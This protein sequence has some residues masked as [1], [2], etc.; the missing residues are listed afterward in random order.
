MRK[1]TIGLAVLFIAALCAHSATATTTYD[2]ADYF[3]ITNADTWA[4]LGDGPSGVT[5]NGTRVI[6]TIV[7]N[8]FILSPGLEEYYYTLDASGI[9]IYGNTTE[10]GSDYMFQSPLEAMPKNV[11]VGATYTSSAVGQVQ[12]EST[13]YTT[14]LNTTITGTEDV[15]VNGVTFKNAMKITVVQTNVKS[16]D[17]STSILNTT[18][19][20]V[21]NLGEVKSV[22]DDWGSGQVH[23]RYIQSAL[24][25]YSSSRK[26]AELLSA[27]DPSGFIYYEYNDESISRVSR[28]QR[29]DGSYILVKSYWSSTTTSMREEEYNSDGNLIEVR[30]YYSSGQLQDKFEYYTSGNLKSYYSEWNNGASYSRYTFLDEDYYKYKIPGDAAHAYGQGR[31]SRYEYNNSDG[32]IG[33]QEVEYDGNSLSVRKISDPVWNNDII[34]PNST[35]EQ[36]Y[37]NDGFINNPRVAFDSEGNKIVGAFTID[38][39]GPAKAYVVKY[40]PQGEVLWRNEFPTFTTSAMNVV[41]AVDSL[42]NVYVAAEK[43]DNGSDLVVYKYDKNGDPVGV[44]YQFNSGPGW[45]E[46]AS[47]ILVDPSNNI[48]ISGTTAANNWEARDLYL[49]KLNS[50]LTEAWRRTYD[51][52]YKDYGG[53]L[54]IGADGNVTIYGYDYDNPDPALLTYKITYASDGTVQSPVYDDDLLINNDGW[55]GCWPTGRD[56]KQLTTINGQSIEWSMYGYREGTGIALLQYGMP[57]GNMIVIPPSYGNL[58]SRIF[59]DPITNQG[60]GYNVTFENGT[61]I[62]SL[63]VLSEEAGF[64]VKKLIDPD[65][66]TYWFLWGDNVYEGNSNVVIKKAT[67]GLWTAWTFTPETHDISALMQ[68]Q[69]L[70]GSVADPSRLNLP[71]LGNW[72]EYN[73]R[74]N[75]TVE[76]PPLSTTYEYDQGRVIER[77]EHND[78][79]DVKYVYQ[80]DTINGKVAEL[81]YYEKDGASKLVSTTRYVNGS[82]YDLANKGNWQMETQFTYYTSG[83]TKTYYNPYDQ[84]RYTYENDNYF[85]VSSDHGQGRLILVDW[86]NG[87]GEYYAFTYYGSSLRIKE[88]RSKRTGSNGLVHERLETKM[89]ESFY[90]QPNITVDG[91]GN[92]IVTACVNNNGRIDAY[93]VKYGPTGTRLWS[94][95]FIEG[96]WIHETVVTT[97]SAGNVIV[98]ASKWNN[99]NNT[100]DFYVAKYSANGLTRLWE[101]VYDSGGQDRVRDVLVD[102]DGNI[103]L[104]GTKGYYPNSDILLVKLNPNALGSPADPFLLWDRLYDDNSSEDWVTTADL[105]AG[106]SIILHAT[107]R[108]P[109]PLEYVYDKLKITYDKFGNLSSTV[110]DL[111]EPGGGDSWLGIVESGREL[112]EYTAYEDSSYEFYMSLGYIPGTD[113]SIQEYNYI[114]ELGQNAM[115]FAYYDTSEEYYPNT[116]YRLVFDNGMACDMSYEDLG[117]TEVLKPLKL[118]TPDGYTYWFLWDVTYK[119]VANQYV[120]IE[121]TPENAWNDYTFTPDTAHPENLLDIALRNWTPIDGG[122]DLTGIILPEL[123]AW[124]QAGL[125]VEYPAWPTLYYDS[126]RVRAVHDGATNWIEYYKD[127]DFYANSAHEGRL[128]WRYRTNTDSHFQYTTYNYFKGENDRVYSSYWC[129]H[130]PDEGDMFDYNVETYYNEKFYTG[131]GNDGRGRM[132]QLKYQMGLVPDDMEK[133]TDTYLQYYMGTDHV[134]AGYLDV[135]QGTVV[136]IKGSYKIYYEAGFTNDKTQLTLEDGSIGPSG[137]SSAGCVIDFLSADYNWI[138]KKISYMDGAKVWFIY[139]NRYEQTNNVVLEK[140]AAGVW[141][142]YTFN[143][144]LNPSQ[145]MDRNRWTPIADPSND[146][147][148]LVEGYWPTINPANWILPGWQL[149]SP[150]PPNADIAYKYD[151]QGRIVECIERI[152]NI[153]VRRVYEWDFSQAGRVRE[154]VFNGV[155]GTETLAKKT[156]Y[157]NNADYEITH[158][159]AWQ[160]LGQA[161]YYES[162]NINTFLTDWGRRLTYNDENYWQAPVGQGRIIQIEESNGQVTTIEYHGDSAGRVKSYSIVGQSGYPES[163]YDEDYFNNARIATDSEGNTVEIADLINN[164]TLNLDCY[165]IKKDADSNKIWSK[166]YTDQYVCPRALTV[167]SNGNIIVVGNGGADGGSWVI[168][169]FDTDGTILGGFPVTYGAG[170]PPQ[171]VTTDSEGN[172]IVTG[173]CKTGEQYDFLTIKYGSSGNFLWQQ[174]RNLG[175]NDSANEVCVDKDGIIEVIGNYQDAQTGKWIQYAINYDAAGNIVGQGRIFEN[176]DLS[177]MWELGGITGRHYQQSYNDGSTSFAL[178]Y[179]GYSTLIRHQDNMGVGLGDGTFY[180]YLEI[181]PAVKVYGESALKE[182]GSRI[183][184]DGATNPP[185]RE[186]EEWADPNDPDAGS[187]L[188]KVT[189]INGDTAWL[190]WGA[191]EINGQSYN[192]VVIMQRKSDGAWMARSGFMEDPEDPGSILASLETL[193]IIA[194]FNDPGSLVLPELGDWD[195]YNALHNITVE[196]PP[197]STDYT[198]EIDGLHRVLT[199][200][201]HNDYLDTRYE[202]QWNADN[203]VTEHIYH[204]KNGATTLVSDTVYNN[205]TDSDLSHKPSWTIQSTQVTYYDSG[206]LKSW[207]DSTWGATFIYEDRDYY[208]CAD[209]YNGHGRGRVIS[210]IELNNYGETTTKTFEYYGDTLNL[211]NGTYPVTDNDG[212]IIPGKFEYYTY[213]NEDPWNN[214]SISIDS[215]GNRYV[216]ALI[217]GESWQW[218]ARVIKYNSSGVYQWA[219]ECDAG[220]SS[221]NVINAVDSNGNVY[222]SV[223]KWDNDGGHVFVYKIDADGNQVG[224]PYIYPVSGNSSSISPAYIKVDPLNNIF[225]LGVTGNWPDNSLF[226]IKLNSGLTQQWVRT[227]VTGEGNN[228]HGGY[229]TFGSN[230]TIIL[231]GAQHESIAFPEYYQVT[232]DT[233]GTEISFE[234]DPIGRCFNIWDPWCGR[235]YK[236]IESDG[237]YYSLGFMEG[238]E[239]TLVE[240]SME[241]GFFPPEYGMMTIYD[242]LDPTTFVSTGV[243]VEFENGGVT[244]EVVFGDEEDEFYITK[245]ID[246]SSNTDWF[247]WNV[248]YTYSGGVLTITNSGS[249]YVVI[250]RT[251]GGVWTASTFTPDPATFTDILQGWVS[252]GIISNPVSLTLPELGDWWQYCRDNNFIPEFPA[253]SS[254]VPATDA[255]GR[256]ISRVDHNPYMDVTNNYTWG[257]NAP[258]LMKW[259]TSYDYGM[260]GTPDL[261]YSRIYFNNFD[262]NLSNLSNWCLVSEINNLTGVVTEHATYEYDGLERVTKIMFSNG[263]SI[264]STY[265][266]DTLNKKQDTFY[267]A[268]DIWQQVIEDYPDGIKLRSRW[269]TDSNS[270]QIGDVVG[271]EYDTLGKLTRKIFDNGDFIL[272]DYYASG[273]KSRETLYGAGWDWQKI[274]CYW[275]AAPSVIQSQWLPD[276]NLNQTGDMVGEEYDNLGKLTRKIFDNG[277]FMLYNYYTSGNKSHEA[278]YGAGWDWQ[279]TIIYQDASNHM[280]ESQWFKDPDP[281]NDGDI[282]GEMRNSSNQITYHFYDNGD[283]ILYDYYT[284]GNKSHETYYRDGWVWQRTAIYYDNT[285]SVM[286]YQYFVDTPTLNEMIYEERNLQNQAIEKRFDNGDFTLIDYY[287]SGNKNNERNYSQGWIWHNSI[288]YWDNPGS[289]MHYQWLEDL[290]PSS[291]GD[292]VYYEYDS[293]GNPISGRY[294]N[295]DPWTPPILD[296]SMNNIDPDTAARIELQADRSQYNS[297]PGVTFTS[298]M[299]GQSKTQELITH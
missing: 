245:V 293:N 80:W 226:L 255:W 288:M 244:G 15:T 17:A 161:T 94:Q 267:A 271:E 96:T 202:Y 86:L 188:K 237:T 279:K 165:L 187:I 98:A 262:F 97:D 133:G 8:K 74:N 35:R 142:A 143:P 111:T 230:G 264:A 37:Y 238:T 225:I 83:N 257:Y 221:A 229:L 150:L 127:E 28:K 27:V 204:I 38:S 90:K 284:S 252:I 23:T 102:S 108:V 196:Y 91:S 56:Y 82:D 298:E 168:L 60:L 194:G 266:D 29:L 164:N 50:D 210:I 160:I 228:D 152:G 51:S 1:L 227:Y 242:F 107:V 268:G 285:S 176:R 200:L 141:Y 119:S 99:G 191:Q 87:S 45:N 201:D 61:V 73:A 287:T 103:I 209:S 222:V 148:S 281:S 213:F 163:Y 52:G 105:G 34:V 24:T 132:Y 250:Q 156:L 144:S 147:T 32:T 273:N 274:V 276:P 259:D 36:F 246:S 44:P 57:S 112:S 65:G 62:E 212:H 39:N 2:I 55:N 3:P 167:D 110:Y 81:I 68:G 58:L 220:G 130:A 43:W 146:Q 183:V 179:Y 292:V 9:K 41:V 123:G 88:A 169:K 31:F 208:N 186:V 76:F 295:G 89:D 59:I 26:K 181:D 22:D 104:V 25:H 101:Y 258:Y 117:D 100:E 136:R 135:Y 166:V 286:Q 66:T 131:P 180:S 231:H 70:I 69:V 269:F 256:V 193:P 6:N 291:P 20:Y 296:T 218:K 21:K 206:N 153:D 272:Y 10:S 290:N 254:D 278:Y 216:S 115:C 5:V 190:L 236:S 16:S 249:H 172:I 106:D 54:T 120:V 234:P 170:D 13:Y 217:A 205:G 116:G 154:T 7:T 137:S 174:T 178:G 211:K 149:E 282:I 270:D 67:D 283:F 125:T 171:W 118:M 240:R 72:E 263:R 214:P 48:Y 189:M 251:S 184:F 134:A 109:G 18:K 92:K 241:D 79:T 129:G 47:Y 297:T 233:N 239:T 159:S 197:L 46:S 199:R 40:N 77:L 139:D 223:P 253:L 30:R 299:A 63:P 232:Y 198:Y 177:L 140:T 42:D 121:N 182:K 248:D 84:I 275:D 33:F 113:L 294:D 93:V 151:A 195:E 235:E 277:N 261:V 243:Y 128:Q 215:S 289:I 192:N 145:L 53:Y 173:R 224:A 158:T 71:E 78:Y 280:I 260:N 185:V 49:V 155:A 4:Y 14:T 162:G 64:V 85:D 138:I 265:Y 114:T 247:L 157:E 95:N 11:T 175:L 124:P 19:W 12:G 75:I 219:A 207:H 126:G 203:T 122:I